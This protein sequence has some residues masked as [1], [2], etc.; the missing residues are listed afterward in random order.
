MM[1][2]IFCMKQITNSRSDSSDSF[3]SSGFKIVPLDPI[4][5][6]NNSSKPFPLRSK[7]GTDCSPKM[8][9]FPKT[10]IFNSKY[11]NE[12]ILKAIEEVRNGGTYREVGYKYNIKSSTLGTYVRES[13]KDLAKLHS[14]HHMNP[15]QV[16]TLEMETL[17]VHYIIKSGKIT[18]KEMVRALAYDFATSNQIQ[19]PESWETN[20]KAG[21]KWMYS[22]L[23]RH[24]ILLMGKP[25]TTS[26]L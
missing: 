17:L 1:E 7:N 25:E 8:P 23:N 21:C 22:F 2:I 10:K 6:E 11:P 24:P 16:F 18:S 3:D 12:T 9:Q 26:L 4:S 19:I 13:S 14:A 20:K 5:F 15:K